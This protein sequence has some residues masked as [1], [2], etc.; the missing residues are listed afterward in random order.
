[1]SR[2]SLSVGAIIKGI[3]ILEDFARDD[4]TTTP[5][6]DKLRS[7]LAAEFC[8]D[9][10]HRAINAAIGDDALDSDHHLARL[11]SIEMEMLAGQ[12]GILCCLPIARA[13]TLYL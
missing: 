1:M 5:P 7:C 4:E 13:L 10:W 2:P 11:A 12:V 9:D 3:A 8:E 6:L